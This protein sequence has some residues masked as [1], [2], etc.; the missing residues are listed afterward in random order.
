MREFG[1]DKPS[2]VFLFPVSERAGCG[3]TAR[4]GEGDLCGKCP[5][6]KFTVSDWFVF[7]ST[8]EPQ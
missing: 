4:A 1:L 5:P 7:L 6:R 3:G 2:C 8:A